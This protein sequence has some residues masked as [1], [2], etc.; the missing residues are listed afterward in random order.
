MKKRVLPWILTLLLAL[1]LAA[2]AGAVE[3]VQAEALGVSGV[4]AA[5]VDDEGTL[6]TWG[7]NSYGQLGNDN[8][9]DHEDSYGTLYQTSPAP[10]LEEVRSVALGD[11]HGAAVKEDGTLWTWGCNDNGQVGQKRVNDK[12]V[13][14]YWTFII[15]HRFVT[16]YQSV[17]IQIMEDVASVSAGAYFTAAVKEDG[18]LWTWGNNY[19]GQLGDGHGKNQ[20]NRIGEACRK[21]PV[22]VMEDVQAVACGDFHTL[23]LKTDGTLWACG[24]NAS[25]ELGAGDTANRDIPVQVMTDVAAISAGQSSSAALKTDGTLW[26]W[27]DNEYGQLG[28]GDTRDRSEPVQVM[29]NVAQITFGTMHMAA[30]KTDGTLWTWGFDRSN[31]LGTGQPLAGESEMRFQSQPVQVMEDAALVS[32]G[33]Y[34]TLAAKNDGTLWAWGSDFGK[35]LCG[36]GDLEDASGDAVQSVPAPLPVELTVGL[37]NVAAEE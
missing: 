13:I 25:G 3:T 35:F 12:D 24:N 23:I 15:P 7:C 6:W 22:Q 37:P 34:T 21:S 8:Q 26:T 27:G 5:V 16:P 29:E 17:P 9:G 10:I 11:F 1:S 32:A 14:W 30:I 31:Q 19:Y 33:N 20:K 36:L 4:C 2:P 28:T 18:T